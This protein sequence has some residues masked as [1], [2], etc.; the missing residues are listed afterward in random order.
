M[1]KLS[2]KKPVP[3]AKKLGDCCLRALEK[4]VCDKGSSQV[5]L[6][7]KTHLPMRD[8]QETWLLSL[9]WED[10]PGEGN[11]DPLQYSSLENHMDR[12]D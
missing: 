11:G 9:G 10:S 3:V 6:V 12:G 4:I 2:S 8:S 1:E 7:V 5:V